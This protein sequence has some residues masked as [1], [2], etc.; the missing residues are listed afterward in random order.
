[1]ISL[2]LAVPTILVAAAVAGCFTYFVTPPAP[3]EADQRL[4]PTAPDVTGPATGTPA[5]IDQRPSAE[6]Q[7]AAAFQRAAAAILRRAPY[8]QASVG[9][10]ELPITGHIPL[11]KRRPIPRP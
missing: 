9:T 8:V 2:R 7:A 11:P 6:E 4:P 10:S 3:V 5:N 1:M